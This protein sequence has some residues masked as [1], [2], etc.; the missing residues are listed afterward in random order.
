MVYFTSNLLTDDF[1][2]LRDI[3]IALALLRPI[4]AIIIIWLRFR[5]LEVCQRIFRLINRFLIVIDFLFLPL[6]FLARTW[7]SFLAA[8]ELAYSVENTMFEQL[9]SPLLP[10]GTE[11]QLVGIWTTLHWYWRAFRWLT[12]IWNELLQLLLI[13]FQ[14]LLKV[15]H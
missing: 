7:V 6:I 11:A 9:V 2:S 15:I 1:L 10:V 13:F 12:S 14:N 4:S 5:V 3:F 8:A